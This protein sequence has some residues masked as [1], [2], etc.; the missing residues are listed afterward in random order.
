MR[1]LG[2]RASSYMQLTILDL[3]QLPHGSMRS[4]RI[5]RVRHWMHERAGRLRRRG[6]AGVEGEDA[7]TEGGADA[8]AG[9]GADAVVAADGTGVSVSISI[10]T[11]AENYWS[12][13]PSGRSLSVCSGGRI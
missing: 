13:W 6:S 12:R 9:V 2:R 3:R 5:L 8:G 1:G 7:E 11:T 4:Q 10:M